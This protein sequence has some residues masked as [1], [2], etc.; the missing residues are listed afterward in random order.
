MFWLFE[1]VAHLFHPRRSNNHRPR[2][3]HPEGFA[4]LGVLAIIAGTV[5]HQLP[6][7]TQHTGNILGFSSTITTSTVVEHT[8]LERQRLGLPPLRLDGVLSQAAA[9]KA[10]DMFA[11]Q[12]WAHFSPSGETPWDFMKSAGY[13]YTV[14]GENL[15][16]D[17]METDDMV[18]AWMNSPTHRENI[19]NDRYSDI[20]I[21]VVNGTLNG[22]ETTLVV[23]MF[24]TTAGSQVAAARI[25][26]T[27]VNEHPATIQ[28]SAPAQEESVAI[29]QPVQVQQVAQRA[30]VPAPPEVMHYLTARET[31][32]NQAVLASAVMGHLIPKESPAL[33][34]P[35]HLTKAFFLAMLIIVMSV[36]VYDTLVVGHMGTVRFVGKNAAHIF[37]FMTVF[38]LVILFRGGVIV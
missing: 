16:R 23:Q 28:E 38:F 14:A 24:G 19:V 12:Y 29:D 15:A 8:N 25:S 3:L 18:R 11:D 26:D 20:G 30:A 34:S 32:N 9:A 36:L 21:A 37:L 5:I 10:S 4:A 7:L 1:T 35:L 2:I 17:F 27:A 22:V 13:R 33:L 6:S 31:Q